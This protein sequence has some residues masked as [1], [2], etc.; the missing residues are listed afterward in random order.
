M[1]IVLAPL[2]LPLQEDEH[3]V[4]RVADSRVPIDLLVYAYRNG[5]TAEEIA[6]DYPTLK[7]ADIYAVLSFYLLHQE[8]VDAYLEVQEELSEQ[9][10]RA[11]LR[12]SPRRNCMNGCALA[13]GEIPDG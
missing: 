11:V 12:Q 1:A 8:D 2:P 4:L 9:K 10:R 5:A 3:G 13:C 7:L 6:L